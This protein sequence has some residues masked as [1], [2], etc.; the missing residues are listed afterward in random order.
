MKPERLVGVQ[1]RPD[2]TT[3]DSQAPPA[4]EDPLQDPLNVQQLADPLTVAGGAP[5]PAMPGGTPGAP[6]E[7]GSGGSSGSSGSPGSDV[8]YRAE[9]ERT[10]G[11]DLGHVQA[12]AGPSVTPTAERLGA[13]AFTTGPNIFF[14]KLNPDRGAVAHE[15]THVLQHSGS[16]APL[17]MLSESDV[18][19]PDDPAEREASAV[20]AA[21]DSGRPVPTIQQRLSSSSIAR[22]VDPDLDYNEELHEEEQETGELPFARQ[23]GDEGGWDADEILSRMVQVDNQTPT[24]G[25]D[26]NACTSMA[27]FATNVQEGPESVSS[28]VEDLIARND[29]PRVVI[30]EV[31]PEHETNDVAGET[32]LEAILQRIQ[33]RTATYED[34]RDVAR[35][36]QI[37]TQRD[38]NPVTTPPEA[39]TAGD[40]GDNDIVETGG[41][42]SREEHSG[43]GD[44]ESL[45]SDMESSSDTQAYILSVRTTHEETT[46]ENSVRHSVTLGRTPD[47]RVYLY[48]SWPRSGSQ[49]L[50]FD[51]PSDRTEIDDYFQ[52]NREFY[53]RGRMRPDA[54]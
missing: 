32:D 2:K 47:G 25:N 11:Q 45:V 16:G 39:N 41:A 1:K 30:Q 18:T 17:A 12:H 5:D 23:D 31:S 48:D 15:L 10:F 33:E 43:V 28:V 26:V 35:C 7:G 54:N 44:M 50:F 13:R 19:R 8:P 22:D 36:S 14:K 24:P 21:V 27:I 52:D 3:E 51:D 49:M 6:S 9:M 53:V 29:G 42:S 37:L 40:L 38:D 34:L 46:D 4:V 20:Q